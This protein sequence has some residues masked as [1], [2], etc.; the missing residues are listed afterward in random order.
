MNIFIFQHGDLGGL[1]K[2]TQQAVKH[3]TLIDTENMALPNLN[4]PT[5]SSR[6][7]L[8]LGLVKSMLVEVKVSRW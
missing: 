4:K 3:A 5:S 2:H 6:Q 8:M 7:L 1:L